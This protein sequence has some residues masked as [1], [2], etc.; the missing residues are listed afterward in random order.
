MKEISQWAIRFYKRIGIKLIG[1]MFAVTTFSSSPLMAGD[2]DQIKL[3]EQLYNQNCIF[4]HQQ[5]AIGKPGVAPSLTNKELLATASDKFL[6]STIRDGR[7]G[8]SMI[9]YAHLGKKK[10]EATV[11]YLRSHQQEP[12]RSKE[13]D[14]QPKAKGDPKQG[15]LLFDQVCS[16]CHGPEGNGYAAGGSGTAVGKQGFL[17]KASDG[18]IRETIR[19]GRSN[20]RMLSFQG[21]AALADLSDQEID[22]IITYLR[23]LK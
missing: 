8:T 4:C 17:A 22:D 16:T 19:I 20:T 10:I 1:I 23:T 15:K 7:S 5:D 12:N 11:A 3:G 9:P 6:L 14:K 13:I 21:P 2:E 18:F